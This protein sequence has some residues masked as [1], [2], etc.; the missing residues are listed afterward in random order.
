MPS[1][2][3]CGD[4]F[5][6]DR[7]TFH[8]S[9]HHCCFV[10]TRAAVETVLCEA[11]YNNNRRHSLDSREPRLASISERASHIVLIVLP[12]IRSSRIQQVVAA[13]PRRR[14]VLHTTSFPHCIHAW[15]TIRVLG[16]AKTVQD[17]WAIGDLAWSLLAGARAE[18][19]SPPPW[20]SAHLT[21]TVGER[22]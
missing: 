8:A 13:Y 21:F 20:I 6:P 18:H 15:A 11:T 12:A 17:Y 10:K 2:C 3:I 22:I 16:K 1:A 4:I 9:V 7:E 19:I 5:R 14:S